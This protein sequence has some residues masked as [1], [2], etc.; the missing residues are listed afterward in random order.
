[1][2]E[3]R[4]KMEDAKESTETLK[5]ERDQL[6]EEIK[7]GKEKVEELESRNARRNIGRNRLD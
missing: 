3:M 7:A 1:M 4:A 5:E 2:D 6:T